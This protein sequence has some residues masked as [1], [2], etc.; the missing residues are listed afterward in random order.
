MFFQPARPPAELA[1]PAGKPTV[2]IAA[3]GT[4]N[5][6]YF[7]FHL[8]GVT[9][10]VAGGTVLQSSPRYYPQL[11]TLVLGKGNTFFM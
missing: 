2:P 5:P 7:I 9:P 11:E 6:P 10:M 8:A 3:D 1:A 4:G